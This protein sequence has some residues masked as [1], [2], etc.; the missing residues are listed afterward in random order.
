MA[1]GDV[2]QKKALSGALS[3]AGVTLTCS[4]NKTLTLTSFT[5]C[6]TNA[7]TART[8][9]VQG[10]VASA[11]GTLAIIP[12]A[13]KATEIMSGLDYVLAAGESWYFSQDTGTDVNVAVMGLEEVIS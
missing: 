10:Y 11:S 3:S 1:I 2:T 7:T 8:A 13:A 9:T 4:A 12:L 5:F 6:N